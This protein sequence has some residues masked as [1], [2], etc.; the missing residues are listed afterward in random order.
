MSKER[1]HVGRMILAVQKAKRIKGAEM[2]RLL[3]MTRVNW[4]S[5]VGRYSVDT[6]LLMKISV[7]MEHDFFDDIS[8]IINERNDND[9]GI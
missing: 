6:E 1:I 8:R 5:I 4:Y 9:N 3:N 2:A 7:A